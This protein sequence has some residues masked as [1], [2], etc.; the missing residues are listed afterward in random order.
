MNHIKIQITQLFAIVAICPVAFS[1]DITQAS[2]E[3]RQVIESRKIYLR[4]GDLP[5]WDDFTSK[6]VAK[7]WSKTFH[8]DENDA[9]WTLLIR[10]VDVRREWILKLNG[11]P[12]GRLKRDE[13]DLL[14]TFSIPRKSLRNGEN[15][16]S[17]EA[18]L[19]NETDDIAIGPIYLCKAS[20]KQ[21]LSEST[22]KIEVR[23]PKEPE[24]PLPCRITIID[25]N[26]S[27]VPLGIKSTRRLAVR[28]GVVYT[29]D[30]SA[31]IPLP[32]GQYHVFVNRGFEY[33]QA[34]REFEIKFGEI[35][36][37]DFGIS[38][39][40]NTKG[41]VACD[42][43]VHTVTHSG[44]GD[45]SMIER[46]LTL[47]G[48]GIELPVS[49]D[50]NKQIDYRPAMAET[51]TESFFTPLIG[52]EVTTD[53]GHFNAF[54][55][56]PDAKIPNYKS[57][58]W[59]VLIPS[60]LEKPDVKVVILNHARD[61]HR[62]FRPFAPENFNDVTGQ[63]LNSRKFLF[64]AME[65]INSAAQ[66]TDQF[67]LFKDWMALTN[68]GHKILPI[69]SSDSHDVNKFIVG[70][71]RTYI[72]VD[73]TDVAK[74]NI[75]DAMTALVN[76]RVSVSCGL[77]TN[78]E[79]NQDFG[80]G[81]IVNVNGRE[82]IDIKCQI[83]SPHWLKCDLI[84][85][86]ENG[87]L[88]REKK[89]ESFKDAKDGAHKHEMTWSFEKRK[90]D[91]FFTILASGPGIKHPSWR[92]SRPYQ[93]TSTKWNPRIFGLTGAVYIDADGNGR[94]DCARDYAH[95]LV[96]RYKTDLT[97]LVKT[98]GDYDEA[99]AVQAAGIFHPQYGN[100]LKNDNAAVWREGA[101][102]VKTGFVRFL[103]AWRK[104]ER[105]KIENK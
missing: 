97:G 101:R 40:V 42:T 60:I 81:D 17:L 30:G 54:P 57:H 26:K 22:L 8:T 48:E 102:Q 64:N 96:E 51:G 85:L 43:H 92:L 35:Q 66:Q 103:N 99:V 74:I 34:D 52:N 78:I 5:E 20:T 95:R 47:A 49:T 36:K 38:R 82:T 87:T 86:Y 67:Q 53:Y 79:V 55:F 62:G 73:D 27:L 63:S 4:G 94:F 11:K 12:I 72:Q 61:I 84:Q 2:K 23:D 70:Q 45:C 7:S 31:E 75:S 68:G 89:I 69:G 28:E 91:S 44:H 105:A 88:V 37:F 98:V 10:Q 100:L 104:S 1:L 58:N 83:I 46:M 65:V 21:L 24:S 93:P 13:N 77:L 80:A 90:H 16:L 71:G 3:K 76:G 59:S 50:H 29:L 41:M 33:S 19:N 25:R 14:S 15:H 32:S 9:D 56:R 6:T 18:K 39:V